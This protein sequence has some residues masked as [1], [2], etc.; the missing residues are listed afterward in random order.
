MSTIVCALLAVR[1]AA[2][3]STILY[4]GMVLTC[5]HAN[6][7]FFIDHSCKRYNNSNSAMYIIHHWNVGSEKSRL[8]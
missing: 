5:L 3:I 4:I 8:I 7:R 6:T 2:P 1:P